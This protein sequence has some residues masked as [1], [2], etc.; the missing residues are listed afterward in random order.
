MTPEE[1]FAALIDGGGAYRDPFNAKDRYYA[2]KL[3]DNLQPVMDLRRD[4]AS[5]ICPIY[6]QGDT[7]S[8]TAN[9]AAAA[10]W[11]EEK[12][13]RFAADWG[14]EGP[15]RL[16][17]YWLART[18]AKENAMPVS[19]KGTYL[20]TAVEAIAKL[21]VCPERD[22]RFPD[23][24]AIDKTIAAAG[25]DEKTASTKKEEAINDIVNKK[26]LPIAF[27]HAKSHKITNYYRLDADRP[28][29]RDK[30]LLPEAKAKFGQDTL[31]RLR[32]CLS[33]GFPVAFSFWF[34]LDPEMAF[35]TKTPK[36]HTDTTWVLKDIWN[37]AK[38]SEKG[39]F[40]P[41]VWIDNLELEYR[42]RRDGRL[43]KP[44]HSVVAI[45][46]DDVNR[47]VLIQNS[48]GPTWG[49]GNGLFYM[50]YAWIS[51]FAATN[52]F[53]TIRV[54]KTAEEHISW[55]KLEELILG[56]TSPIATD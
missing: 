44:G 14:D 23:F 7:M 24:E 55:E 52:D 16:F 29:H 20:R 39:K 8:C 30:A 46:Y 1:S 27:E 15:S 28:D 53:W 5:S 34:Y 51:D 3:H 4:N 26:P 11:Y 43:M 31:L 19:G 22:C 56:S 25:Y 35:D 2:P 36:D 48:Y 21:G 42:W 41:H 33:E 38:S 40:P 18:G 47:R 49:G 12:L 9:A 32:N 54:G 13:G 10:F 17:I 45:G 6:N 50:P 37:D